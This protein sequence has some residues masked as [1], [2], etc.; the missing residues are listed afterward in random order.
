MKAYAIF[1]QDIWYDDDT[2]ETLEYVYLDYDKALSKLVELQKK[3][4]PI[5]YDL[6]T[7]EISG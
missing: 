4:K 5:R 2:T 1:R 3:Y 7:Y 6:E